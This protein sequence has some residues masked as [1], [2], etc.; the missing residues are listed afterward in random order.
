MTVQFWT[1]AAITLISAGISAGFSL[2]GLVGPDRDDRFARYAA[3][4]SVAL[5]LAVLIAIGV[6]SRL[7]IVFLGIAMTIVQAL[8]G[9]IGVL[10]R[11]PSRTYGPFA[12]AVLNTLAIVWL[13]L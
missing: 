6:R 3:S 9:A 5:L 1:C 11:D 2:A 4:R 12:L 10:G 8:D 7:A 13:L